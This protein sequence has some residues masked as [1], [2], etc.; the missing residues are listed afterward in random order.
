GAG[1]A[2]VDEA[3]AVVV[4]AVAGAAGDHA[5]LDGTAAGVGGGGA[6]AGR[7]HLPRH[8]AAGVHVDRQIVVGGAGFEAE[9]IGRLHRHQQI[10]AAHVV[11]A[12][13]LRERQ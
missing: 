5:V 8:A 7:A 12:A 4:E 6:G 9:K 3:V 1:A 10:F 13:I 2:V 11:V